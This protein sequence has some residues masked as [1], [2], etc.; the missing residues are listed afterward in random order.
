MHEILHLSIVVLLKIL[1]HNLHCV[2]CLC[3]FKLYEVCLYW[4]CLLS[5]FFILRV[6][7]VFCCHSPTLCC[8][9]ICVCRFHE[10]IKFSCFYSGT[11][12][13]HYTQIMKMK[14]IYKTYAKK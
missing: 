11:K 7:E 3:L 6:V 13:L 9:I 4:V 2:T 12:I 5:M 10:R 14:K 1:K 8:V